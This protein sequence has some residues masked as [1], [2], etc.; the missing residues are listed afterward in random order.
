MIT[1]SDELSSLFR[2]NISY[3]YSRLK[4]KLNKKLYERDEVQFALLWICY[5][6]SGIYVQL[7]YVKRK[8]IECNCQVGWAFMILIIFKMLAFI[9]VI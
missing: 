3:P 2:M 6:C 9:P 5:V 1:A 8:E 4:S 7:L